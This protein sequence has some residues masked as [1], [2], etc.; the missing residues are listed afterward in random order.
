MAKFRKYSWL[1]VGVM[2]LTGTVQASEA[3][4]AALRAQTT[5]WG[6]A[7]NAGDPAGLAAQYADDALLMPPGH[8][9]VRGKDAILAF[10][11][12]DVAAS[13]KAGV[14]FNIAPSTEVG[15][16]G[17]TGWES[18]TYTVTLNG[19]VLESGKFLSVSRK[20]DGTWHYI[21]DTW[22]SD[23]APAPAAAPA[24]SAEDR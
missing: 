1:L 19:A 12:A 2:A 23:A 11:T 5:A 3:D 10:F 20:T 24:A 22:N 16:D 6:K 9:G 4:E 13:Q 15:V 17:E 21:R 7:Y 8:A 18:G 14:V